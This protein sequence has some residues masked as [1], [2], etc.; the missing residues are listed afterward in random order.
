VDIDKYAENLAE[1]ELQQHREE[2]DRLTDRVM[3]VAAQLAGKSALMLSPMNPM[4]NDQRLMLIG[5]AIETLKLGNYYD[6]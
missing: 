1:K 2:E 3:R 6:A 5:L 4:D